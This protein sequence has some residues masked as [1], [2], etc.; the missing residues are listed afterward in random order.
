VRSLGSEGQPGNQAQPAWVHERQVLLDNLIS[1][2][3]QG[4]CLVDD[5]K[6]LDV[7][8]LDFSK[9]FD[10]A[11]HSI[12]LKKLAARGLDGCTLLLDEELAEWLITGSCGEWS[13]IQLTAGHE[14]CPPGLSFGSGLVYHLYQ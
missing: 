10:T 5:G 3:D 11:S 7:F 8:Y 9:A 2:Y 13:S 4:T 12:L 14:W 6:S 1:F